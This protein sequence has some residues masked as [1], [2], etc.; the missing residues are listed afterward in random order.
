L[1][2]QAGVQAGCAPVAPKKQSMCAALFWT[3]YGMRAAAKAFYIKLINKGKTAAG[4][5]A[6][7]SK[8]GYWQRSFGVLYEKQS[9]ASNNIITYTKYP[10]MQAGVQAGCAPV[11]PKKQSMRAVLFWPK[12]ALCAA[13]KLF[14]IKLI[15]NGKTA[16]RRGACQGKL[17]YWQRSFGVL[18]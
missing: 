1:G 12:H 4:H 8:L 14:Y 17:G 15:N 18:Y 9:A 10:S 7:R 3:K 2:V 16:A 5:G 6:Y 11:A 13:A